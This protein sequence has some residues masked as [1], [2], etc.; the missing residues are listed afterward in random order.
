MEGLLAQS[1]PSRNKISL[2]KDSDPLMLHE[3]EKAKSRKEIS[4]DNRERRRQDPNRYQ[5]YRESENESTT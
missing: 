4:K 3:K 2:S 5:V 1:R